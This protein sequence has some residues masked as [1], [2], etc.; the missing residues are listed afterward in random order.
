VSAAGAH[1]RPGAA[2]RPGDTIVHGGRVVTATEVYEASIAIRGETIVAIGPDDA[3]PEAARH[4]DASGKYVLPGAIDCHVHLG[5]EY[6]TW[7]TGPL[8]AAHAG[9]TTIVVFGMYDGRAKEPLPEAIARTRAEA[10]RDSVVDFGLHF[11][12]GNHP[13]ILEGI[14]RAMALGVSSFKLFMTYK[15]RGDR[16][17][18]DEFIAQ[19]ME[20]VAAAGGLT[21][22]H[23]ENGDVIEYLE[24]KALAEGRVRPEDFPGTCPDW[25]E[26]EA[27]NRAIHL[28]ALT[29]CPVYV[30][31]L[32]TA[33]GLERI[34]RAQAAGQRVWTET[35]PQYLLL[36][37]DEMARWGPLAKIGPPLRPAAGPDREALWRG[38]EQGYIA[39][40]ASD[41]SPRPKAM[42][43]AGWKNI[44][45]APD[46]KPV[47]HGSPS[48]ETLLPLV[49]TEGVVKRGLPISWMAR[50]LAENP[51]RTFGL[52]PRKGVI[53]VGS[54][55]DLLILDPEPETTIRV[56]DHRGIAGWTLYEGWAAR[57]RP[58]MTML[59]GRVL[60]HEGRLEQPPGSGRYL[61]RGA[62]VP[63]LG[64]AVR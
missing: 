33:L 28:G 11:I 4:V 29:G 55:A 59:R 39:N 53:R 37:E 44:F 43:E 12:L 40:V 9:L 23:C 50:V 61:A 22:L 62:P 56:E 1:Q 34:K 32:S 10:E 51:A 60:L 24:N 38:V 25:T 47:P 5:A 46:G 63:P 26:E 31:H 17:C 30:V 27:I 41:H 19:T 18:S 3:L 54:D 57:G 15:K 16:M 14:P 13:W 48:I 20:A 58:W 2:P 36:T 42:K 64:G 7:K 21:Q 52:Y 35:C 49:Y 6:D 8:A 45:V